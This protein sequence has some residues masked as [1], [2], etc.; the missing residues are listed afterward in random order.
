MSSLARYTVPA[1]AIAIFLALATLD[2]DKPGYYYDEVIFVPVSLRVLG[3]CAVDAA[4]T[5]Q[6]G[7]FPLMQTLGYVGAVKAWLHAPV[8]A[9]FGTSVW[10][11]RLPSILLG[12]ATLLVLWSFVRRELGGA[13]AALLLALLCVDPVLIGHA[14]LDWGPHMLAAFLRVLSLVALWRWLQTGRTHWLAVACAAL[15]VGFFDK[16]NFVWV[17]GAWLGAL[18]VVAGREA[19]RRLRD[20]RPWQPALA[21]T[22]LAIIAIG[23]ATLVRQAVQLDILGNAGTFSWSD[24]AA[25]VWTLFAATFSGTSVLGWVFGSDPPVTIAFNVLALVQCLTAVV[26]LALWR[27]WTPARRLLAFL[28]VA[29]VLLVLAIAATRQV[30]GTHHLVTVWPLPALH[31]VTLLAIAAQHLD[32]T[33]R[34]Q[35]RGLRTVVAT[36]GAVVVGAVLAWNIAMDVRY[37]D[38]FENDQ[39]YRPGFDP[40]IGKLSRR[41]EGLGVDRVI[42]VDWGLHQQLVTLAGPAHAARYRE[43]SWRLI[44]APDLDRPDLRRA[45]DEHVAGKRV[46][47]VLHPPATTVF[48]GARERLD[49][50]LARDKPCEVKEESFVNAAG[51]PLYQIVVADYRNCA[52]KT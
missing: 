3:D 36:T 42:S 23:A 18:A 33:T 21:G 24:H 52:P 5:R 25:K 11:V 7:C 47:F 22:T 44:D 37:V 8:F 15:V 20:G 30:G 48:A 29:S 50:L 49:Q 17:I 6:I 38:T 9:L 1:I 31:L 51:K 26:L 43:W 39:D 12:A 4:V 13:W 34:L 45:V 32:G 40:A 41:L 35:G 19:W 14:R 16:I 46:A 27:P 28:T 2:L 10:A